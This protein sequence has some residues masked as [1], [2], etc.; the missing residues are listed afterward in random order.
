MAYPWKGRGLVLE[1]PAT[2]EVDRFCDFIATR[3]KEDRIDTLVLLTR[4]RY[5][6]PSHPE[7]ASAD[8]LTRSDAEKIAAA[9]RGA[10]IRLIPKMNLLGHQ[11]GQENAEGLLRAHPELD[12]TPEL[13]EVEYCRSICPS[14]PDAL[15]LVLDLVDDMTEA[16]GA[17]G[18]HMGLDEVF[19]ICKCP[20][21]RDRNPAEVFASWVN[22]IAEHLLAKGITPFMWGDRLLDSRACGHGPWD[23]SVVGTAPAI[24]LV[25]KNIVI[26]DWHYHNWPRFPSVEIFAEK[27]FKMWLCTFNVTENAKLFLDYAKEHDGGNI[28]GIMETTWI[29]AKY[30][31]DCMDGLPLEDSEEWFKDGT[32]HIVNCYRWLFEDGPI[33]PVPED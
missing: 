25:N 14:H 10:G 22:P 4:Y 18:F 3:L 31:M 30:F 13:E 27:G 19:E 26:C 1:A 12:E 20:R 28:E 16:F 23:A 29:P 9:C 17:D 21:C 32:P 24:D 33:I 15:P 11:T 7:C 8:P 6:F 5:A 2:D